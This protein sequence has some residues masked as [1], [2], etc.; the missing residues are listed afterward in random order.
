MQRRTNVVVES[1][2]TGA[3]AH[4]L[5]TIGRAL[6]YDIPVGLP[7]VRLKGTPATARWL[8]RPR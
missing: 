3:V 8:E 5:W 2:N 7:T 1:A 6:A 4:A